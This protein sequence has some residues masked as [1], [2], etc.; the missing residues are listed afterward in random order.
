MGG[1]QHRAISLR[2]TLEFPS[3]G[4]K[5]RT[6]PRRAS[7]PGTTTSRTCRM[8]LALEK[9]VRGSFFCKANEGGK[10]CASARARIRGTLRKGRTQT[11]AY[12]GELRS[13]CQAGFIG[14]SSQP[15]G[16]YSKEDL[17]NQETHQLTRNGRHLLYKNSRKSSFIGG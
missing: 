13:L 11:R 5:P 16:S 6:L 8:E 4:G 12:Y 7:E 3:G 10:T 15:K 17:Q 9:V 2:Q 14:G 1:S